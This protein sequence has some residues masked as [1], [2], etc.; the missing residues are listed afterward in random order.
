[1]DSTAV[2][3]AAERQPPDPVDDQR[4]DALYRAQWW[5]MLRLAQGLWTT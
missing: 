4:F 2:R 5:P 3:L 1:M